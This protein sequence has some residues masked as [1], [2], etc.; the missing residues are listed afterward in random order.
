MREKATDE[1]KA[2]A[3]RILSL[4]NEPTH[5]PKCKIKIALSKQI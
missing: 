1:Y 5:L 3:E 2:D 4:A